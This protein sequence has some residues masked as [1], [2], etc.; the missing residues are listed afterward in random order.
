MMDYIEK[1][2]VHED[3]HFY[4]T[5]NEYKK[6]SVFVQ[7]YT[8][9]PASQSLGWCQKCNYKKYENNYIEKHISKNGIHKNAAHECHIADPIFQ[10][11]FNA[12]H[13]DDDEQAGRDASKHCYSFLI[14]NKLNTCNNLFLLN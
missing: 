10:L 8:A 11:K 4:D 7:P 3:F 2:I 13:N 12:C 14:K 1:T 9:N 6:P 5:K